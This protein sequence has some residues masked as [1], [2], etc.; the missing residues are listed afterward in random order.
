MAGRLMELWGKRDT[1]GQLWRDLGPNRSVAPGKVVPNAAK[2][3]VVEATRPDRSSALHQPVLLHRGTP[4]PF[5]RAP[6]KARWQ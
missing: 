2:A 6:R 3:I 5:D 1:H 4:R